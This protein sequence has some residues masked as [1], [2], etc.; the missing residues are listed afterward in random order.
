MVC[1]AWAKICRPG[2]FRTASIAHGKN[3]RNFQDILSVAGD[4]TSRLVKTLRVGKRRGVAEGGET[5]SL[6]L[7]LAASGQRLRWLEELDWTHP[8][9]TSSSIRHAPP[10]V[11]IALAALLHPMRTLTTLVLREVE[12]NPFAQLFRILRA[13]PLIKSIYLKSII[14][15]HASERLHWPRSIVLTALGRLYIRDSSMP[16]HTLPS[17]VSIGLR[18]TPNPDASCRSESSWWGC[19]SRCGAS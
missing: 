12:F 2:I 5:P 6:S 14:V 4:Q 3:I 19:K 1:R 9:S 7:F 13:A 10:R 8:A 11:E 18:G 17:F 15:S 16:L